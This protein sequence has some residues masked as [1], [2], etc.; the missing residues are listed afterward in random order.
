MG[1]LSLLPIFAQV[2]NPGPSA[3]ISEMCVAER[4][5]NAVIEERKSNAVIE[6][7]KSNAVTP[8]ESCATR[9]RMALLR[10]PAEAGGIALNLAG[11]GSWL[12]AMSSLYPALQPC[13]DVGSRLVISLACPILMAF[14]LQALLANVHL[15]GELKKPKQCGSYGALLMSLS[16][17]SSY[18]R[19]V[20][21][22]L[23]FVL[24]HAAAGLQFAMLVWYIAW[25]AH[26]RSPPVPYWFPSTVGIGMA[27]IAGSKAG[28]APWLQW[29]FLYLSG[30]LCA[31]E[32]PWITLRCLYSDRIAPAPSIFVHG[33]PV[34][35]VS[36]VFMEVV[37]GPTKREDL[38]LTVR[39]I[40]HAF[41]AAT[42]FAA[43]TTLV[44]AYRRRTIL[45]RFV[46]SRREFYVHQEWAGLTFPLVATSAY[47]I[48]Y[49]DRISTPA[50]GVAHDV[51]VGWASCLGVFTLV[52][53]GTIDW[54]YLLVGMPR[55]LVAGLPRVPAPPLVSSEALARTGE[56]LC[57]RCWP[58]L[59]GNLTI[60][61]PVSVPDPEATEEGPAPILI[62]R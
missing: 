24:V 14:A 57:C 30:T 60:P 58:L 12:S 3:Q 6:E 1:F 45:R 35:L 39:C 51:A 54:F 9:L 19:F 27:A 59:G 36:L 38:T 50:A 4:K 43:L 46:L 37:V 22:E 61:Q 8:L 15:R 53:V 34:S 62:V 29:T 23:A 41:L 18:M 10:V 32:W 40:A 16:L 11:L 26:L 44:F 49:A 55:W 56:K 2:P 31:V 33:A 28:M 21:R 42:T 20:D 17:C 5:S 25:T 13:Y 7:R 52:L 48:L 47:A